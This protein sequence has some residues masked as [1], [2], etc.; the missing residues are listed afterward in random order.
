M[1]DVTQVP[2]GLACDCRCPGCGDPLLAK[3]GE[4]NVQ[5]FAHHSGAEC[6]TGAETALHL[7]AKQLVADSRWIRLPSLEVAVTRDDPECGRFDA[8]KTFGSDEAWHFD[9]VSLE[10]TIG[11]VRPDAVGFVDTTGHGIEIR[12][13]HAV[14]ADKQTYLKGL[15]LPFIEVNLAALTGQAVTFDTLV[16]EVLEA[17]DNKKWLFHPRRAEW[18]AQLLAGFDEWRRARLEALAEQAAERLARATARAPSRDDVYRIANEKYRALPNSMKWSRLEY[19]LGLKRDEFPN[20]LR[21]A[22]REGAD[23]VLADK[24]LWQ[25]SLFAKFV[26]GALSGARQGKPIPSFQSLGAWLAQRFGAR[27]GDVSAASQAAHQYLNYLE[28]CGFLRYQG[29]DYIVAYDG[30]FA[31]PKAP[32]ASPGPTR[33]APPAGANPRDTRVH[34]N[35]TW[36]DRERLTKWATE[37]AWTGDGFRVDSFDAEMLLDWLWNLEAPATLEEFAEVLEHCGGNPI[38]AYTVLQALGLVDDR[39]IFSYGEPAPWASY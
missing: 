3:K 35:L 15:G 2:R 16:G 25:G 22:L 5:H 27:N 13:T 6:A 32:P 24:D 8:R 4:V 12:V 23:A 19:E 28:A 39:R 17:V 34:W 21:V 14:D 18:E 9:E 29:F 26:L 36:P 7:A 30:L 20:H 1:V 33:T 11:A 31:P 38:Q 10:M 37:I